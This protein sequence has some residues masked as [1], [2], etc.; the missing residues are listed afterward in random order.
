MCILKVIF[1]T[2]V[3]MRLPTSFTCIP[4]TTVP[5]RK[6]RLLA[7]LRFKH[8]ITELVEG[9]A[10]THLGGCMRLYGMYELSMKCDEPRP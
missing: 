5:Y 10:H 1:R 8:R 9:R 2:Q 6:R 7:L 4:L 3:G